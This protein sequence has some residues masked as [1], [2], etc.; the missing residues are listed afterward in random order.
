MIVCFLLNAFDMKKQG[1]TAWVSCHKVV[2]FV[3]FK[4]EKMVYSYFSLCTFSR[5]FTYVVI[6]TTGLHLP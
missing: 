5:V 2:L 4:T 6:A 3:P 1:L